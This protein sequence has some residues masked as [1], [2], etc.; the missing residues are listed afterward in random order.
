L[1]ELFGVSYQA[2][3]KG[4]TER[5]CL[6]QNFAAHRNSEQD[7][8]DRSDIGQISWTGGAVTNR[9]LVEDERLRE[10]VPGGSATFKGPMFRVTAPRPPM[11]LAALMQADG[12]SQSVPAA[13]VG[14]HGSGRVVY[15]P[16]GIDH[17][18]YSYSYPYQRRLLARAIQWAAG[19]PYPVTV[20]A[21]MCIQAG[22]FRQHDGK[23]ER[24]VLHLFNE[25]TSNAYHSRMSA[26]VPHREET[27]PVSGIRVR[28]ADLSV[29]RIHLE[30]EGT[31][32]RAIAAEREQAVNLP[33][34]P[35][36][37]MLV[38]ELRHE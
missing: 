34:L 24:L 30:P 8:R 16:A 23:N 14:R 13:V 32:L 9:S 4:Q 26:A 1:A 21:P 5:G 29:A 37:T 25:I 19:Q 38:I 11:Q 28:F 22:F 18:Y 27:V 10:L 15:L 20:E 35:L 36:H 33:P 31:E 3:L 6:D 17:A 12:S 7:L 2:P